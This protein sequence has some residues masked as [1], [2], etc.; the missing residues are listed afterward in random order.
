MGERSKI[1]ELPD[2]TR[3]E[4]DQRLVAG[5][6]SGYVELEA[7]LKKQG[8]E[9]GKSSIH[10]YGSQMERRLA[11]LK[12]STEQA[13]ALVAAAPDDTDAMSRA[14]MQMLQQRLFQVL[15]DMDDVDPEDVDLAK[16]AKA[17]APLARASIAQQEY[18]RQ[19]KE[20][21]A[22]AADAADRIVKTGG[23]SADSAAEI[24]RAILGI[25]Q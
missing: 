22:A 16:L 11:E 1:L 13:R 8:F 19:V 17:I 23:L 24:R 6:F 18:M 3:A 9:V 7:W 14:T 5:G 12:A 25:A 10:R 20:R 21:A 15:R 4:L 2:A